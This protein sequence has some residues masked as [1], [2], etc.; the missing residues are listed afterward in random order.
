MA[1]L[2]PESLQRTRSEDE[3]LE[4]LSHVVEISEDDRIFPPENH[5]LPLTGV[6]F[7]PSPHYH[8]EVK[9]SLPPE[10]LIPPTDFPSGSSI[11]SVKLFAPSTQPLSARIS[12][13]LSPKELDSSQERVTEFPEELY[14]NTS[15][16]VF[17]DPRPAT[18]LGVLNTPFAYHSEDH[19]LSDP[20]FKP[21]VYLGT[22]KQPNRKLDDRN[23]V[24]ATIN[25]K[26]IPSPIW[27]SA[28][29]LTA[30]KTNKYG[31]HCKLN[32]QSKV[33]FEEIEFRDDLKDKCQT[34]EAM[35]ELVER[36]IHGWHETYEVRYARTS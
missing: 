32:R 5:F 8:E 17:T 28:V 19:G 9:P 35:R 33:D 15:H 20:L 2:E 3:L 12:R 11:D 10:L 14:G 27:K 7:K 34:D 25:E 36:R 4:R 24:Y 26:E 21:G 29:V 13:C 30:H 18:P 22:L 23:V 1:S 6:D 31:G 16:D